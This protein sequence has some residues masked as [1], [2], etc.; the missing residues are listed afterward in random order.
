MCRPRKALSVRKTVNP[1]AR[2]KAPRIPMPGW[3]PCCLAEHC[4]AQ[5]SRFAIHARYRRLESQQVCTCTPPIDRSPAGRTSRSS[6][7]V[8]GIRPDDFD[9]RPARVPGGAQGAA[10]WR[11]H[12]HLKGT[13]HGGTRSRVLR[14]NHRQRCFRQARRPF[15]SRSARSAGRWF[16]CRLPG[17]RHHVAVHDDGCQDPT[18]LHRLLPADG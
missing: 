9:R 15:R 17:R 4:C 14:G 3:S 6:V 10:G 1:S 11:F 12:P 13:P 16:G 7:V 8:T 2:I 5:R 18:R